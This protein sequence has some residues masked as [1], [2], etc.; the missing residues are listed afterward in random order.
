M[1]GRT[2]ER[3]ALLVLVIARA[4]TD[5]VDARHAAP[6]AR[7]RILACATQRAPRARFDI[8]RDGVERLG[9]VGHVSG[10]Y[11][12]GDPPVCSSAACNSAF[13]SNRSTASASLRCGISRVRPKPEASRRSGART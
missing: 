6:L 12:D 2:D 3:A 1:S 5:E 11:M 9:G 8:L 4:L 13:R 10:K 7:H